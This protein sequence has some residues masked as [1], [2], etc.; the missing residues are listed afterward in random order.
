MSDTRPRLL[1]ACFC[2]A[3]CRTCDEYALVFDALKI[4]YANLA[5]FLW[6]DIEDQSVLMDNIDVESFPTLL[7]AEEHEIYFWGVSL[8]LAS[9]TS[10]LL[11]RVIAGDRF[12]L[13]TPEIT[14]LNQRLQSAFQH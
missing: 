8:P 4:E 11:N 13:A 5:Q 1:V 14:E 12:N 10:H 6:V 7:I 3:W 9:T 2:A